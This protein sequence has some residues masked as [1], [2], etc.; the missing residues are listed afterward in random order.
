MTDYADVLQPENKLRIAN[1]L[2]SYERE[3]CHQVYLLIVPSLAGENIA[4]FSQRTAAAWK[5]GHFGLGNG[6]LVT[7][8]MAEGAVRIEAGSAFEWF[9]R[10]GAADKILKEVMFPLFREGRFI[11]G[12]EKGL[13]EIMV[14][15]RLKPIM[16][17]DRPDICK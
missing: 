6:F 7:M 12:I 8:A 17:N 11:Q 1:S 15:G 16:E 14:K 13:A 3:T 10:D 4:E 5:I 2:E 9:V